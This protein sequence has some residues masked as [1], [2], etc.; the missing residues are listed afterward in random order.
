MNRV[1]EVPHL[2]NLFRQLDGVGR[3]GLIEKMRDVAINYLKPLELKAKREGLESVKEARRKNGLSSEWNLLDPDDAHEFVFTARRTLKLLAPQK[4]ALVLLLACARAMRQD[5]L[6]QVSIDAM[7]DAYAQVDGVYVDHGKGHSKSQSARAQKKRGKGD[8]GRTIEDLVW[9]LDR[10]H[11]DEK[12]KALWPHMVTAIK[13]WAGSAEEKKIKGG[14]KE[15]VYCEYPFHDGK[16][17]FH[18]GKKTLDYN[19]FRRKLSTIRRPGR[20]NRSAATEE[21]EPSG[22]SK[23]KSGI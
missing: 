19:S 8:D 4:S 2:R 3:Q 21:T 14:E 22:K 17:P 12:P 23:R 7:L 5:T 15:K 16:N 18:D 13:Q 6:D 20:I 1:E 9:E 10:E 11:P